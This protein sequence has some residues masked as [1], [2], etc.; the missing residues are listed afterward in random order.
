M[1]KIFISLLTAAALVGCSDKDE[2]LVIDDNRPV[3]IEL[4]AGVNMLSRAAIGNG[5]RIENI[6][7]AGWVA[8]K[9]QAD[10]SEAPDWHTHLTIES[11]SSTTAQSVVWLE[12]QY[13][14]QEAT[15]Y[16]HMKAWHPCGNF[17]D[18]KLVDNRVEIDNDGTVDVLMAN[19]IKGSKSDKA[20]TPLQFKHM[21]S[22]IKFKVQAGTGLDK[23]T[24]INK[25]VIK[26]AQ[27][28]KGFDISKAFSNADAITYSD[29]ADL[30]IP[31]VN[32]AQEITTTAADAGDPVMIRPTNATSFFVDVT[33][34]G[35]TYENC[36]V[37]LDG[38]A[39][40][41]A[42]FACT[43][44]LTFGQA[45]LQLTALVDQW[46]TGTGGATME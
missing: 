25:I 41:K 19:I 30:Q 8:E 39:T 36:K 13:Y 17:T 9:D 37:T 38:N 27:F 35:T 4:G 16:T 34:S 43:V 23:G 18:K 3:P 15:H 46:E 44:T 31:N 26:D 20:S 12:Q 5:S 45:G 10:Y 29:A 11:A 6:G 2:N 33:T 28:P 24:T 1:K 40:L 7:I 32:T 22:Q 42:G 14:A 21:T